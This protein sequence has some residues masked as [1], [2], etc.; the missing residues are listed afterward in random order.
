MTTTT[1]STRSRQW[2]IGWTNQAE[3]GPIGMLRVQQP[4]GPN[5]VGTR[6]QVL[7]E[8]EHAWRVNNSNKWRFALYANGL[9]LKPDPFFFRKIDWAYDLLQSDPGT[10]DLEIEEGK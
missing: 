5:V 10:W 3:R 4:S 9:E 2:G 7:A 1:I 8:L 6:K